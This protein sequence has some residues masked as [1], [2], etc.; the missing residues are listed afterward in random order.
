MSDPLRPRDFALLLLAAGDVAPLRRRV[1]EAIVA[2]DPEPGE[3][4]AALAQLIEEFSPPDGPARAV[5]G[6][7]LDDWRL[8]IL[9][10]GVLTHLIQAG[11]Q[12][13]AERPRG[14]QLPD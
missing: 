7:V 1:L 12:P 5:A 3:L 9:N 4:E 11:L 14:G 8:A 2:R 6:S 10:P 13:P